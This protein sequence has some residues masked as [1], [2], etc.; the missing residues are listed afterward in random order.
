MRRINILTTVL[1]ALAA[2]VGG[3]YFANPDGFKDTLRSKELYSSTRVADATPNY[4]AE[5]FNATIPSAGE[6]AKKAEINTAPV[7]AP[8]TSDVE[9]PS[10]NFSAVPVSDVPAKNAPATTPTEAMPVTAETPAAAPTVSAEG[11]EKTELK[12]DVAEQMKDHEYGSPSAPLTVY[13]YSSL[14]CPHC[15][16]FHNTILPKVKQYY[17]DTG[18]VR[19]VVRTFPH[20]EAAL[21][22]EMLARCQPRDQYLKMVDMLFSEQQRWAMTSTPLPNLAVLVRIAGIDQAKFQ[23]CTTHKELEAA[24]LKMA[25]DGTEKYKIGSTPTF[26]FNDGEKKLE[27]GGS[28]ESF[29]YEL[30][31]Q[32]KKIEE[33]KATATQSSVAPEGKL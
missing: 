15:A 29:A 3:A 1:I 4:T 13:D 28:Y 9:S 19:W 17:I 8:K 33:R 18:K 24:V 2:A 32:L 12:L 30:D 16:N 11:S 25:Q 5:A 31:T 26:I 7:A 20:N 27:G 22:A 23:A 10:S 6:E 14:T 21:R